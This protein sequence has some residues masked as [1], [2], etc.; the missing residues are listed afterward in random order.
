MKSRETEGR[1][2]CTIYAQVL[3]GALVALHPHQRLQYVFVFVRH[4]L[5]GNCRSNILSGAPTRTLP[6]NFNVCC[7]DFASALLTENRLLYDRLLSCLVV[8]PA[9][10]NISS[11]HRGSSIRNAHKAAD[12]CEPSCQRQT[13]PQHGSSHC[14]LQRTST[15]LCSSSSLVVI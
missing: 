10:C 13:P 3:Q 5:S 2:A 14:P 15:R 4:L 1:A 11:G 7:P 6:K 8:T 12:P 9:H